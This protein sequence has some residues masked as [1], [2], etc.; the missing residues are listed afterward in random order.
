M[1]KLRL[2]VV[3]AVPVIIFAAV[4]GITAWGIW[5]GIE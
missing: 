2:V 4:F 5:G 3:I 1:E